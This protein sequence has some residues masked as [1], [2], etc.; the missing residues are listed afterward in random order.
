MTKKIQS[1]LSKEVTRDMPVQTQLG[2]DCNSNCVDHM[3]QSQCNSYTLRLLRLW[4]LVRMSLLPTLVC[5][6]LFDFRFVFFFT[7]F[8]A[9][10]F[11]YRLVLSYLVRDRILDGIIALV[12]GQ[13]SLVFGQGQCQC[14]G[15]VRLGLGLAQLSLAWITLNEGLAGW[16]AVFPK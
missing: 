11:V 2:S 4:F 9:Y 10:I 15:R 13:L 5:F 14:L 16:R 7:F 12:Q 6:F 8:Q 3:V 1:I